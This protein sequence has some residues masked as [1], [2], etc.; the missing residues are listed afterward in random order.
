MAVPAQSEAH[1]GRLSMPVADE[2]E[3][4]AATRA[5]EKIAVRILAELVLEA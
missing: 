5:V 1:F 4:R 3:V 2:R